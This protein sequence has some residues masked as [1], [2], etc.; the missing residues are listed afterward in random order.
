M[1]DWSFLSPRTIILSLAV[2]ALVGAWVVGTPVAF[3]LWLGLPAYVLALGVVFA[4]VL[5]WRDHH[6]P[7]VESECRPED[8]RDGDVKWL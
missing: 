7:T 6:A 4:F 1:E 8:A 2:G 3:G 5:A